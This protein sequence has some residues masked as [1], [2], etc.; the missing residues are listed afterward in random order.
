MVFL[1]MSS[2]QDASQSTGSIES[3]QVVASSNELFMQK[4]RRE[5]NEEA[6]QNHLHILFLTHSSM[7]RQFAKSFLDSFSVL[8]QIYFVYLKLNS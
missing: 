6:Y 1:H 4:Y 2:L 7:S 8:A 3:V 5:L